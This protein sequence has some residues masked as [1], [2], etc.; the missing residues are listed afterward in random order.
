ML[1]LKHH[2]LNYYYSFPFSHNNH[3]PCYYELLYKNDW[4]NSGRIQY[5]RPYIGVHN[6][7]LIKY[8]GINEFN[9]NPNN[10]ILITD[11]RYKIYQILQMYVNKNKII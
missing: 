2:S 8:V 5:W 10:Y 7:N 11:L 9:I 3:N 1:E 6:K 4:K